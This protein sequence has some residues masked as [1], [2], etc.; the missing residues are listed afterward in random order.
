[1]DQPVQG[2][3]VTLLLADY[4]VEALGKVTIVGAG[5]RHTLPQSAIMAIGGTVEIPWTETNRPHD[6]R[7][8]LVH[9]DG[10]QVRVATLIG[11]QPFQ[12]GGRFEAGRPPGVPQGTSFTMPLALTFVRPQLDIGT[13]VFNVFIDNTPRAS[14]SFSVVEQLPGQPPR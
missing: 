4:A 3:S 8:E 9:Q 10:P 12:L 6:L 11:E 2:L 7:I 14:L 1:V 5:W 13:Y